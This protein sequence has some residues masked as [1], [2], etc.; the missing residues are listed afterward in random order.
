MELTGSVLYGNKFYATDEVDELLAAMK[1]NGK[2]GTADKA[3]L[4]ERGVLFTPGPRR[5]RGPTSKPSE[6][7]RPSAGPQRQEP[8]PDPDEPEVIEGD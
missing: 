6:P 2:Q 8:E 1:A 4:V 5:R 3:R 7:P